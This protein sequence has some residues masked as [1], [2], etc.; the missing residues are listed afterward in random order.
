MRETR[1]MAL[2]TIDQLRQ[3]E[4]MMTAPLRLGGF[5]HFSLW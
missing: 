5:G 3:L 4:M 2:R 1:L